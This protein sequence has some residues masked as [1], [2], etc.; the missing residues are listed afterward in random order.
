MLRNSKVF[1]ERNGCL[2]IAL[3]R[4]QMIR[5]LQDTK[6]LRIQIQDFVRTA[7]PGNIDNLQ[8]A[9]VGQTL[10]QR[11]K[12]GRLVTA[13]IVRAMLVNTGKLAV[14]MGREPIGR[15]EQLQK[16]FILWRAKCVGFDF[17]RK[18]RLVPVMSKN[19]MSYK[20]KVNFYL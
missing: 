5:S 10:V 9:L 16:L 2:W 4:Q 11:K 13:R 1:L 7:V 12:L 6:P 8:E 17:V 15:L 18:E 20:C 14:Q 19:H 3:N